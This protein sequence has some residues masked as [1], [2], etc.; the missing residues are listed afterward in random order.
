MVSIPFKREG[1]SEQ[2]LQVIQM[3]T[4]NQVSIPFKREGLS[5]RNDTSDSKDE[6]KEQFQ[7]PSNGKDFP[8]FSFVV[9]WV[10]MG[11][12]VSIPFKREGLSELISCFGLAKT[13]PMFQFPSNGKDFP[14]EVSAH[15]INIL[16][17]TF[18]FPSNGKDF[19]NLQYW[20]L[21]LSLSNKVSIP[22]KREGLSELN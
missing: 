2:N 7:F 17:P 20:H 8:N 19:P 15:I 5:E 9:A 3:I 21:R 6:V 1:L 14:N 10:W 22:F 13:L 4:T 16:Q 18:Q 12:E 11:V